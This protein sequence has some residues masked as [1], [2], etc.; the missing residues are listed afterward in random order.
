MCFLLSWIDIQVSERLR[1]GS[2]E[3]KTVSNQLVK[4]NKLVIKEKNW[5]A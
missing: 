4:V 3:D 2:T 1:L 5:T